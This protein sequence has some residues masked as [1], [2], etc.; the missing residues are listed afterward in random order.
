M[1]TDYYSR[2]EQQRGPQP[3]EQMLSAIARALRLT[4]DERDHLFRLA[5]HVP[6]P[7]AR[8]TDHV[9]PA[10]MRV[11]DR[12]DTPAQVMSDLGDTLVQNE[13]AV[14]LLG[15][16]TRYTGPARSMLYRWFTDPEERQIYPEEDQPRHTRAYVAGARAILARDRDDSRAREIVDALLAI[17][18][19]FAQLWSEHEVA[20]RLSDYKRMTHPRVGTIELHCQQLIAA[21][22]GQI[23]LVYTAT[24]GT[25]DAR[26]A[27][28][29]VGHRRPAVRRDGARRTVL[30][31]DRRS[32]DRRALHAGRRR[33]HARSDRRLRKET[34]CLAPQPTSP[35]PT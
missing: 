10:L 11:L 19:E 12:L 5:G 22:E 24:P 8:R 33:W 25:E 1:S 31:R 34:S 6:A 23:L 32:L 3:S 21:D 29:V 4:Q 35:C 26:Q 2:L 16:Q 15:D 20:V 30:A 18:P 13:L 14:A 28:P 27:A 17:S 7:R 9:N